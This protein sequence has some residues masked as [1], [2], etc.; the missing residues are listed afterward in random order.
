MRR[1]RTNPGSRAA[2]AGMDSKELNKI[3]AALLCAGLAF[4]AADEVGAVLATVRPP[5]EPAFA[6]AVPGAV[7]GAAPALLPIA[8]RLRT[9]SAA[10]GEAY[11]AAQ[12]S[13]CHGFAAGGPAIVGPDLYGVAGAAVASQPGYDY[14]DA[15]QRVGGRWT[16]ARLD[17]WLTRPA[18][19]APGTKMGFGGIADPATR[20]DTVAYLLTLTAAAKPPA[21]AATPAAA[22]A[23]PLPPPPEQVKAG[24]QIAEAQCSA[25]HSFDKGG[26]AMIGPNLYGVV[27]RPIAGDASYSYSAALSAHH[28]PWTVATLNDWLRKPQAFAPGTK[29]GYPGLAGDTDRAAV[30]AY[31]RSL[32]DPR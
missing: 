12:C 17:A 28:G 8:D 27:G 16:S 10:H 13:A 2:D 11:A 6:I 23:A 32:S 24:E 29:M 26:S 31:L 18:G 4:F 9:A 1:R 22:A 14:S 19:F 25:C 3:A 21:M 15:L 20:A 5:I 30:V 7:P